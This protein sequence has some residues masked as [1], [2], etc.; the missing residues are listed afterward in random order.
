MCFIGKLHIRVI[1]FVSKNDDC[2]EIR[3]FAGSNIPTGALPLG[4]QRV[5]YLCYWPYLIL[6][7]AGMSVAV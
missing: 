7:L 5:F 6:R 2:C 4:W 1:L 3:E